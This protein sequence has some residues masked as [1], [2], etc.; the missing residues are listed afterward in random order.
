ML[1]LEHVT[2]RGS[3]MIEYYGRDIGV[4]IMPTGVNP[5]RFLE[6]FQSDDTLWK[7]G[8]L[9]TQV[10]S[11]SQVLKLMTLLNADSHSLHDL[12]LLASKSAISSLMH[13]SLGA[14]PDKLFPPGA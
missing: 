12:S 1:G 8:E 14:L 10:Y 9:L 13:T 7:R 2:S 3:I 11:L 4:K 5:D 6:G